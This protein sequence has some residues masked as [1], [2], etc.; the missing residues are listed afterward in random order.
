MSLKSFNEELA[1]WSHL[2]LLNCIGVDECMKICPVAPS[3]ITIADLNEAVRNESKLEGDVL[4][5]T[6]DCIQCGRCDPVCPTSASRSIMM[7]KLKE[8]MALNGQSPPNHKSYF[9]L[10]GHDK[11]GL[12]RVGFN[13]YVKN[14]WKLSSADRL[15]SEKLASHISKKKFRHAEYLF[16]F[17]CYIFTKEQSAAQCIDIADKLSIDYEVL[18]GLESCCGWPQLLAGRTDEAESYH[19]RLST[20]VKKTD[21]SYV[22]TGCAECYMSL[23]KIKEKYDMR[24]EPLTTP[25]WLEKFTD[26]LGLKKSDETVTYH[27]SCHI[28]RKTNNPQPARSL[29]SKLNP[30][31]EMERSGAK[32]AFC[33]GYWGLDSDPGQ[34]TAIHK[35]RYEEAKKTGS[36]TMV[37]ECVTCLESFGKDMKTSGIEVRDIVDI[38]HERMTLK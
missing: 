9:A 19:E 23:R 28:S 32:D 7:L 33:C 20:L 4:K 25:M 1:E 13:V 3:D 17:G 6:Q 18:G 26:R 8:K 12:K 2:N 29:L 35:S 27:D 37:V 5:F 14:K 34:L 24:F 38:V 21:P 10:K 30:I 31:V 22:I 11:S 36:S 15:K 16:Y